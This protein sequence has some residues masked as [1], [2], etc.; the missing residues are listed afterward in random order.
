MATENKFG[1]AI[2]ETGNFIKENPK[3]ILWIG[4]SIAVVVIAIAVVKKITKTVAGKD[5]KGGK[6]NNQNII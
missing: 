4:G 2:K 1:K 5:V 3:P 6:F